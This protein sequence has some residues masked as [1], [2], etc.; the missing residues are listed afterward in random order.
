MGPRVHNVRLT[1]PYIGTERPIIASVTVLNQ[2]TLIYLPQGVC[3]A[4]RKQKLG[5]AGE[6]Y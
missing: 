2:G 5:E 4:T 3:V 1:V 6:A